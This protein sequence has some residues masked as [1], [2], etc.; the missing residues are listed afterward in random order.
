M[1]VRWLLEPLSEDRRGGTNA[2]Y[3]A[4]HVG[5]AEDVDAADVAELDLADVGTVFSIN[6]VQ[7]GTVLGDETRLL[8]P[9]PRLAC[10]VAKGAVAGVAV[11]TGA[12]VQQN[13]G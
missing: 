6:T 5:S 2:T 12:E 11:Q 3:D 13:A 9:V 8:G 10:P 7:D 4:V 1:M